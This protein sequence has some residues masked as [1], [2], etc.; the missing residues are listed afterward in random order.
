MVSEL[1][2]VVSGG[3]FG[4]SLSYRALA[5]L[6]LR[7]SGVL[8]IGIL[9]LGA[10]SVLEVGDGRGIVD[11]LL[12]PIAPVILAQLQQPGDSDRLPRREA[13]LVQH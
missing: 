4:V 11:V 10:N 5:N 7:D 3:V 13:Q 12:T 6:L 8:V 1:D 2:V 9:V